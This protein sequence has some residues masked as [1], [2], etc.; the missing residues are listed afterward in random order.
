MTAISALPSAD[1]PAAEARVSLTSHVPAS[2]FERVFTIQHTRY[3]PASGKTAH[4]ALVEFIT[5]NRL[6]RDPDLD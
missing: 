4:A 3:Q 1:Q 6:K 5:I 2:G